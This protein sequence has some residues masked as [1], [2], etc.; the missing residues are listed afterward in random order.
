MQAA[1]AGQA[2][3]MIQQQAM[4]NN[5]PH[6]QMHYQMHPHHQSKFVNCNRQTNAPL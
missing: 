3:H 5:M 2:G 1:A 4:A 6:A